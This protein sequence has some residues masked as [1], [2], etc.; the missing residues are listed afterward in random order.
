M[1]MLFVERHRPVAWI[2][3]VEAPLARRAHA[4]PIRNEC[5]DHHVNQSEVA[6]NSTRTEVEP[7][8]HDEHGK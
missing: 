8:N 7:K 6:I 5:I 4:A 3:E 2:K 1:S